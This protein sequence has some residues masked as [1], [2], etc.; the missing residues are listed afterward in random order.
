MG[1]GGEEEGERK[2]KKTERVGKHGLEVRVDTG[3]GLE[4]GRHICPHSSV[5]RH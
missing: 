3:S 4:S 5:G 1:G 2:Q